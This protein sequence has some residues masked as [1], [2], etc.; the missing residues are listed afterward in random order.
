MSRPSLHDNKSINIEYKYFSMAARSLMVGH[1]L[2]HQASSLG[3]SNDYQQPK[4]SKNRFLLNPLDLPVPS[5]TFSVEI[6]TDHHLLYWWY[7]CK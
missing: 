6:N 3:Y 1:P 7:T 5:I 4:T 2:V